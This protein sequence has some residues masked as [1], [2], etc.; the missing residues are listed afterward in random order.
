MFIRTGA[1]GD[2]IL[3]LPL[4]RHLRR[5]YQALTL[6]ARR[7]HLGLIL[8]EKLH[9]RLIDADSAAAAVPDVPPG[10]DFFV[11]GAPDS[12][13]A[14]RRPNR[15]HWI[16]PRPELPPH[17]AWRF[18]LDAGFEPPP[19]L[20]ER[21]LW[22][23]KPGG[24]AL[25]LHPGSGG[26]SKNFP[27]ERFAQIAE[28][29]RQTREG[30]VI[31]SFGEA[32]E[33]LLSPIKAAFAVKG[34]AFEPV[35]SP[36]LPELKSQL[37][38]RAAYYVGNDSGVSHLAGALGVPSTALFRHTN[39]KVWRPLGGCQTL[40]SEDIELVTSRLRLSWSAL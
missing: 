23:R 36:P 27:P 31:V 13:F 2:F 25:W 39:A 40:D 10:A 21:P 9:D 17:A 22:G 12:S 26:A 16:A 14:E 30:E 19:D 3:S 7:R 18:F 8:D 33:A 35:L 32:D 11:F 15:V 28:L 29:W 37:A 24:T 1:L 34:L 6:V 4:L 38:T 5:Q 20:L